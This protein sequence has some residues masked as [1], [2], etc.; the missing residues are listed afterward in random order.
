MFLIK[1]T[2][3][4]LG[5]KFPFLKRYEDGIPRDAVSIGELWPALTRFVNLF[6]SGRRTQRHRGLVRGQVGCLTPTW[7]RPHMGVAAV[8]G[9]GQEVGEAAPRQVLKVRKKTFVYV[10][11]ATVLLRQSCYRKLFNSQFQLKYFSLHFSKI[12]LNKTTAI[13]PEPILYITLLTCCISY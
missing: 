3:I 10:N 9:V 8:Q 2:F 1:V 4:F 7:N 11:W 13:L 12:N 6:F 5:K